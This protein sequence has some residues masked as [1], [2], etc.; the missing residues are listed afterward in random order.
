MKRMMLC[1][2]MLVG[3]L[4]VSA[5]HHA[6][7]VS[8]TESTVTLRCVGYGKKA[9]AASEDAE[10]SAIKTLLFVGATGTQ[11]AVPLIADDRQAVEAAFQKFFETFYDKG[12]KDFVESSVI[13]VPF[14]KNALKQKCLTLDVCVRVRPLRAHLEKNGIIRKFGL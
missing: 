2:I 14:G 6:T 5:Q 10:L 3:L 13:V 9:L 12:Y 7:V 8:S 11:H 1:L 4:E